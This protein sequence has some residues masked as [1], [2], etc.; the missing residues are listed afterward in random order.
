MI[1]IIH[2]SPKFVFFAWVT[3]N[4]K[5]KL[6][7]SRTQ[8]RRFWEY[9]TDEEEIDMFTQQILDGKRSWKPDHNNESTVLNISVLFEL[10]GYER[11]ATGWWNVY[12]FHFGIAYENSI[13]CCKCLQIPFWNCLWEFHQVLQFVWTNSWYFHILMIELQFHIILLFVMH[14]IFIRTFHSYEKWSFHVILFSQHNI[15]IFI[16]FP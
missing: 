5:E 3:I 10:G 11:T 7:F 8:K 1:Q 12:K 15:Y 13:K 4:I 2:W 6:L 14:S 16:Y 9:V